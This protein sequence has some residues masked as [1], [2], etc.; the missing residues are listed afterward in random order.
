MSVEFITSKQLNR[1]IADGKKLMIIDV[2]DKEEFEKKHI[3]GAVN[4]PKPEFD[5]I[6][7]GD[8]QLICWLRRYACA[9]YI[10]I[11]CCEWGNTSMI[12]G[13]LLCPFGLNVYSLFGGTTEY[14]Q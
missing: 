3:D 7:Y 6:E 10:L 5:R 1:L 2:R 11:L 9:G 4:I 8:K 14:C 12:C 13:K